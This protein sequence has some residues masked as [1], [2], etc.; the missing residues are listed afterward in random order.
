MNKV[1]MHF[2]EVC[3]KYALIFLMMATFVACKD[4]EPENKN[5]PGVSEVTLDGGPYSNVTAKTTES[6]DAAAVYSPSEDMTSVSF[7]ATVSGREFFVIVAFPGAGK[8]NFT[9]NEDNCFVQV[10]EDM[11]ATDAITASYF[12]PDGSGINSG[13]VTVDN[14]GNPG[15][16]VSGSFNGVATFTEHATGNVTSGTM[17]GKFSARRLN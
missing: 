1:K 12:T 11:T 3:K 14:Y 9:W 17:K 5:E 4:D 13:T 15:G 7:N 10:A 8:G 2:P 16:I 6:D